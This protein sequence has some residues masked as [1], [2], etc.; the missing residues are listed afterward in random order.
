[1]TDI[2]NQGKIT[3]NKPLTQEAIDA[4][5]NADVRFAGKTSSEIGDSEIYVEDFCDSE[6]EETINMVIEAVSPLGYVLNGEV[7]Y[8]GDY[9]GVTVI[10][11]NKVEAYPAEARWMY[12]E[13]DKVIIEVLEKRG[14]TVTKKA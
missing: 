1:M 14:Y 7:D 10:K 2:T 6:F 9:D 5:S 8:F 13:C 4:I 3:L 12:E 11:D